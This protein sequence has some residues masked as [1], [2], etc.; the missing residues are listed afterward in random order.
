MSNYSSN[1][2]SSQRDIG[3]QQLTIMSELFK[4]VSTMQHID[5][6]LQWLATRTVQ[7]F[8]IQVIE[9]WCMQGT[10]MGQFSMQL[11]TLVCQDASLPRHIVVN[12]QTA[13][14]AALLAH[15]RDS[16]QLQ[17][18]TNVF[19]SYQ[20]SLL[21]RYGLNYCAGHFF[22]NTAL[23]IPPMSREA[24]PGSIPTPLALA[25]LFFLRQSLSQ[26]MIATTGLIL[27]QTI[28]IA[29]NRGLLTPVRAPQISGSLP[30]QSS[31]SLQQAPIPFALGELIPRRH[32]DAA[33]MM[34]SN[35]LSR[36]VDIAD[37]QARRLY[38]AINGRRNVGEL[39]VTTGIDMKDISR[40]IRLL[41][42]EHRI[43]LYTPDGRT[44]DTLP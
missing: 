39:S 8:D 42:N 33:L 26:Q 44:V 30:A 35:P 34:S 7:H 21:K 10:S 43:Q 37:N 14:L 32:T 31:A 12:Q 2:Y 17:P 4:T 1:D 40:A 38:T 28:T 15:R 29:S 16:I 41:L 27:E 36:S 24:F 20:A 5:E 11:R 25:M 18:A 6:L 23:L 9:I 22:S 13:E 19:P 3:G